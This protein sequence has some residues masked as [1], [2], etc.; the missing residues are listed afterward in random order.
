MKFFRKGTRFFAIVPIV[1]MNKLSDEE[2]RAIEK[3]YVDS[4][5]LKKHNQYANYVF[6]PLGV[7]AVLFGIFY[8]ATHDWETWMA[9]LFPVPIAFSVILLK[10][11]FLL[12]LYRYYIWRKIT[13]LRQ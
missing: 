8:G 5:L 1:E 3:D 13:E 9:A 12:F 2:K 7:A 10:S 6:I 4:G 11:Y